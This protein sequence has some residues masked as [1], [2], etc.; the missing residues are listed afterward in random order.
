MDLLFSGART[1]SLKGSREPAD[2]KPGRLKSAMGH[3]GTGVQACFL[4]YTQLVRQLSEGVFNFI[5]AYAGIIK[6][7]IKIYKKQ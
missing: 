4:W 2:R 3:A 1:Y 5:G 6:N 7:A